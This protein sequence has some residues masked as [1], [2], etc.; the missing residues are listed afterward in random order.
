MTGGGRGGAVKP[1]LQAVASDERR[2]PF[3]PAIWK[4]KLPK[5]KEGEELA[6]ATPKPSQ[7]IEQVW[8]AGYHSDVGGGTDDPGLSDVA[9][10]WMMQRAASIGL[11][12]SGEYVEKKLHPD[13]AGPTRE[14]RTGFYERIG[15]FVRSLGTTWP[16]T[17][18]VHR[19]VKT[20]YDVDP[21]RY[22]PR[23]LKDYLDGDDPKIAEPDDSHMPA[24]PAPAE[25]TVP[26]DL[27]VH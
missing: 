22:K 23:N 18:F 16:V 9:L 21:P 4:P 1:G 12:F 11:E 13:H 24:P 5:L 19:A 7:V 15:T 25:D 17:E 10:E 20:R 26:V 3:E 8:F 2:A 6:T 14:S 27:S